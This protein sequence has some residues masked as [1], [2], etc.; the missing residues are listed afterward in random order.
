MWIPIK[1][2]QEEFIAKY[3][4]ENYVYKGH[5]YM[6][7]RKGNLRPLIGHKA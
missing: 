1:F 6:E 4:L 7:I 2:I 5:L 3:K